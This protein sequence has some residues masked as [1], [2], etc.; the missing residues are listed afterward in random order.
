MLSNINAEPDSEFNSLH[1][2][3]YE[4]TIYSRSEAIR[5]GL[6]TKN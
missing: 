3:P 2:I 5:L 1:E 4:L 6:R